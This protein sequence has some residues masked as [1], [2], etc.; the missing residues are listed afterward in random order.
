MILELPYYNIQN[1]YEACKETDN[2]VLCI[3]KDIDKTLHDADI[4]LTG[5]RL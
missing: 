3:K 4:G 5:R 1:N 2:Y